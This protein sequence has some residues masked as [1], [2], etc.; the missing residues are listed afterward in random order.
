MLRA[1]SDLWVGQ[2]EI[3]KL[4]VAGWTQPPT[5]ARYTACVAD[6][7]AGTLGACCRYTTGATYGNYDPGR[8]EILASMVR[9]AFHDAA[10]YSQ[11]DNT[12]GPNGCIDF[13]DHDN[14]GL[15]TIVATL[16]TLKATLKSSYDITMSLADLYQY[17]GLVA[18][19]CALP[20]VETGA[21]STVVGFPFQYGRT[22]ADTCDYTKDT[23]RMPN[24]EKAYEELYSLATRWGMSMQYLYALSGAHALGTTKLANSGYT[25]PFPNT[26]YGGNYGG[27]GVTGQWVD[28]NAVLN[29][30]RYFAF[31]NFFIWHRQTSTNGLKHSFVSDG[32]LLT[33]TLMLSPLST[34]CMASC[35]FQ[36]GGECLGV[37]FD[38]GLINICRL[39]TDIALQYYAGD[40]ISIS[41]GTATCKPAGITNGLKNPTNTLNSEFCGLISATYCPVPGTCG[42]TGKTSANGTALTDLGQL[43][44]PS[45]RRFAFLRPPSIESCW[46]VRLAVL[47]VARVHGRHGH[48]VDSVR[49]HVDGRTGHVVAGLQGRFEAAVRA[50]IHQPVHPWHHV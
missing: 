44:A 17:A 36:G 30:Q 19:W 1:Q 20:L 9:L 23:G 12:G 14:A 2:L 25:T 33:Q 29:A 16:A 34:H 24:S 43:V 21:S 41:D 42:V 38:A 40:D 8:A 27:G 13:N 6:M 5:R 48:H 32:T 45:P 10:P 49:R 47:A 26:G 22:T 7:S 46:S 11:L 37:R 18:S 35:D 28:T 39:N 3:E 50:R 31:I 4:I 15:E